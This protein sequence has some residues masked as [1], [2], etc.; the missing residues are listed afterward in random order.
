MD[1][2]TADRQQQTHKRNMDANMEIGLKAQI[3]RQSGLKRWEA[4]KGAHT[5]DCMVEMWK[6][7]QD[8][9]NI[10]A[11]G[12]IFRWKTTLEA[13]IW[14]F[15]LNGPARF[16]KKVSS[17]HFGLKTIIKD[18]TNK[19]GQSKPAHFTH[20]GWYFGSTKQLGSEPVVYEGNFEIN[21][22]NFQ[23]CYDRLDALERN[24]ADKHYNLSLI[25]FPKETAFT[26]DTPDVSENEERITNEYITGVPDVN[27]DVL[28]DVKSSWDAFTFFEKV[29]ED[30]LKNK[31]Y[32]YQL[33][34]YM[35][36]TDKQ[37]EVVNSSL[38]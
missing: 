4:E 8:C 10:L 38:R 5:I 18:Y 26:S 30:E 35:W 15:M 7:Y 33:Q 19:K 13:K 23:I 21:K 36:L 28:I 20:R 2:Q 6:E 34:G 12:K 22:N 17:S 29:V 14:D 27:T 25:F 37:E 31:D 24:K 11:G 1:F 32:Y 9:Y 16:S 3:N